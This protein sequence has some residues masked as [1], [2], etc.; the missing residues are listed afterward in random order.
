MLIPTT[1]RT[2]CPYK[3]EPMYWS[4]QA[5]DEFLQDIA[6]SYPAPI[7]EAAKIENLIAFFNEKVDLIV[8]GVRQERPV[9]NWS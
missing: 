9:T 5:E 8:D 1:T 3:G 4:A 7:P 6:W 2:R